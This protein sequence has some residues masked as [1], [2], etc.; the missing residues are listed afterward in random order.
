[1]KLALLSL[2]VVA[3]SCFANTPVAKVIIAKEQVTATSPSEERQLK[4]KAKIYKADTLKTGKHARAQFRFTEGT[5]V[6][7]GENTQF[8]V[9]QFE[10]K[11]TSE[12]HFEFIKGAFRVVTGEITKVTNPNFKIKTP[13]GSIGI[14]GTDF[15]GGNLYNADTIDI[16]LLDSEHPIVIENEF[17]RV[18]IS[19]P[20]TGTTLEKGK[21]PSKPEKWSEKKLADAVKTIQ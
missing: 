21:P 17:G 18:V 2:L 13:M 6:T 5:I 3:G 11:T 7:L 14:R 20:R 10:H 9:N 15:W 16:I 1:M 19:T 4:R 8:A 12:A